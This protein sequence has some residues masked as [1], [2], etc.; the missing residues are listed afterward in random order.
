[1]LAMPPWEFCLIVYKLRD[2]VIAERITPSPVIDHLA[3]L[4]HTLHVLLQHYAARHG[5]SLPLGQ[6]QDHRISYNNPYVTSVPPKSSED[7]ADV[8][9]QKAEQQMALMGAWLGVAPE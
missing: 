1:M 8:L 2:E 6:W 3:K 5:A 7:S 4:D 9:R